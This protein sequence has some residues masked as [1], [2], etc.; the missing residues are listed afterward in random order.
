MEVDFQTA[1]VPELSP[2]KLALMRAV[3]RAHDCAARSNGN[4][5]SQ[6]AGHASCGSGRVE[7]ALAASI[8]TLGL[9]HAPL[10]EA[11][12][13]FE[14][15]S[16]TS[17]REAMERGVKIPG[18]GNSFFQG[19]IDPAWQEVDAL[20]RDQFPQ[21]A[22]RIDELQSW[23]NRDGKDLWPNAALYSA[24]A[25]SECGVVHGAEIALFVMARLPAWTEIALSV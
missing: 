11:R 17:V 12:F 24:A 23:V 7:N 13:V 10:A 19:C 25:F 16:E 9:R 21:A 6:A 18:F 8:L 2:T 14:H 1:L 3:F 5:S 20:L 22:K 15:S 4:L